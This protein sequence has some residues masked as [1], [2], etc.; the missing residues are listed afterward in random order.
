MALDDVLEQHDQRVDL[1]RGERL[2]VAT[3]RRVVITLVDQFDA[4]GAGVEPG[5]PLPLADADVPGPAVFV[6]Q[7]VDGRRRIADQVV[8]AHIGLRQQ[9]QRALQIGRGVVQHDVLHTAVLAGG[10]VAV[11]DAQAARATG[12]QDESEG[13]ADRFH[14]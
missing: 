7:A 12:E 13:K 1:I 9:V 11:I 3:A 6:H 4:D 8:A 5:T 14:A 10:G 2:P